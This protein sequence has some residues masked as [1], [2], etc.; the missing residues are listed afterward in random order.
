MSAK[1][2]PPV[3]R[4]VWGIAVGDV[5]WTEFGPPPL[6]N[7]YHTG[8]YRVA[9]ITGPIRPSELWPYLLPADRDFPGTDEPVVCLTVTR[10]DGDDDRYYYLNDLRVRDGLYATPNG[11]VYLEKSATETFGQTSLFDL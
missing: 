5:V 9:H 3:Y 2:Q 10:L 8:P 6:H 1:Q 7:A 11:V 4:E